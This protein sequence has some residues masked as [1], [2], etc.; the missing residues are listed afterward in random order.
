MAMLAKQGWRLLQF[1]ESLVTRVM[2]E[3][4]YPR[5]N[6]LGSVLGK[7]PSYAWRSIWQAKSLIE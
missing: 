5:V 7:R 4:F 3:K 2:R 6:F 1:P